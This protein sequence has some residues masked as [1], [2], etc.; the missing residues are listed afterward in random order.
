MK[1]FGEMIR[2]LRE[3]R[4]LSLRELARTMGISAP[5]LSDV[6]LGRRFPSSDL[7]KKLAKELHKSVEELQA[8]DTRPP[9]ADFKRLAASDPAYGFAL[10]KVVDKKFTAEELL[11]F[12]E[13]KDKTKRKSK[14]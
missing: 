13:S 7:L 10:R 9:L 6:E 3:A 12:A 2:E 14:G 4:D 8:Y 1:S 11:K 5:F